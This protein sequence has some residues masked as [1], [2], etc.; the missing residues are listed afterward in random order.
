[1]QKTS[2]KSEELLPKIYKEVLIFNSTTDNPIKNG[3]KIWINIGNCKWKQWDSTV[4]SYIHLSEWPKPKT[5]WTPDD[6]EDVE[7]EEV[8][9][10]A[11][12]DAKWEGHF[13][14]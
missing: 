12:G 11:G 5:L 6:G 4:E 8:S 1:M 2:N 14:N 3:Q 7:Q 10:I 9:F 13:E